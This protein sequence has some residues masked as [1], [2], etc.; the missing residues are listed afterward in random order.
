M[1]RGR[2]RQSGRMFGTVSHV[3][4]DHPLRVIPPL[5]I[6]AA[7]RPSPAFTKLY[8]AVEEWGQGGH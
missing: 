7:D 1:L 3:P 8:S 4:R 2:E 6:A 5:A